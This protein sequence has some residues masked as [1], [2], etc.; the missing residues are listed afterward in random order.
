MLRWLRL[1]FVLAGGLSMVSATAS[2]QS[3]TVIFAEN[4]FPVAD[5]V[6]VSPTALQQ[7]F[8]G[9]RFANAAQL[10]AALTHAQLLVLPYGSA[11]PEAVWP[12]ILRYLERGGNLIVLGGKPF[13]RAAYKTDKGWRLRPESVTASLELFIAD[14]QPTPGSS[15]LRFE[16]NSDVQPTLPAF[17]W[18]RAFSP[19]IRL[20]TAP[21][22]PKD[23]GSIGTE[24][25]ELTTLAWGSAKEHRLDAPVVLIDRLQHRFVGGRWIFAACEP[26]PGA[27]DNSQLLHQLQ[28]LALRHGD[29]FSFSP[30]LPLFLSGEPLDFHFELA[31]SAQPEPGDVLAVAWRNEQGAEGKLTV[32]AEKAA[33]VV[34]PAEAAKGN[35]LHG[36]EATLLRAGAPLWT[37]RT[38][39]W[40]RDLEYL[41]SGP[42]LTVGKDYF[43]LDGRPLPVVGT[44]Y[45]SSDA[46]RLYL[47]KPNPW[48]WDQDMAQIRGNGLNMLR[49]GIWSGWSLLTQ[50]DGAAKEETL[51]AIEAFLMTA[52]RHQ[53]PVQFNLFA[54]LPESLGGGNAYLDPAAWARQD[55]YVQSITAR[56][57]D[58]PFLAWDLINE[59]S[60]NRNYWKTLPQGD[61]FEQSAWK[62][63]LTQHYPDQAALLAAWNEPALGV[64]RALQ[65]KPTG[66]PL[67]ASAQDPLAL[68][69][70]GA[71]EANAAGGGFNP[72]KDYDYMLFT[73]QIFVDWVVRQ[74]QTIRATGS[75]QLITVGQDEGGVAWRLSPA[76]FSPQ[77]D[78]TANHTWWDYDAIL[79]ASLSAKMPG[80]PMLIQEMGE[81]RRVTPDARLRLSAEEEGWQLERKLALSFAQGAGGIEWV[82]NVNARMANDNEIPIGAVRPDGSQKPE[83]A[84]LAGFARFAA[85]HPEKFTTIEPP[86]VTL[87]SSQSAFFSGVGGLAFE[88]QKKALR[89][90]A[91]RNHTPARILPENRFDAIGSPRL[92]ILPA[93]Q[94]LS[95]PAWQKLLDYVDRGGCLLITGPLEHDEHWGLAGRLDSLKEHA[96]L[97]PLALRESSLRLPGG[98]QP[99]ELSF[100]A[101]VQQ[102]PA[103]RLRFVDGAGDD[104]TVRKIAHGKGK[105]L[106][107]ADPVE[108]TED[109]SP[110]TALYAWA[111]AEA[112]VAP[113]YQ[114]LQPL[115]PGVLAFP[116]LLPDAV[117][118]SFSSES[119]DSSEVD[120]VDAFTH[121]RLHFLLP[122]ERGAVLL[123]DRA[124]GKVL[125][126]YGVEAAKGEALPPR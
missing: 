93:A 114:Q 1:C 64:G 97:L 22:L 34:L 109:Y 72:L 117:L 6:A 39:F 92:A 68:P 77:V 84:V 10:D 67:A 83:V 53:L 88:A 81:Q 65:A 16:A 115:S 116:T 49:S 18:K 21:M 107:V 102:S 90:L 25:A 29:R 62:S 74:R 48:V 20:A 42:K 12:A 119:M 69:E 52:R 99:I 66:A 60:A 51:R 118:Y 32:P 112:G 104:V 56:F 7:G 44:T 19:V 2:A 4:G 9:A 126:S 3:A 78:F 111:L 28:T 75:E 120:L 37:Y 45:M 55:R 40:M 61:A 85:S 70:A 82:W 59:P 14:Y 8:A 31:G 15:G 54:F 50:P 79:W 108:L 86:Q 101:T 113:A 5:S 91:Y 23:L 57:H 87:L 41:R 36:V 122:A 106:W 73:Q 125:S 124:T 33:S 24:D 71:F 121:A 17:A 43:Q 35:G 11:Y 103:E 13:L 89:T 46:D 95:E 105:I 96:Q 30:R 38:G 63:W 47:L 58:L 26:E 94:A 123:L 110:A 98:G 80:K 76:F 27:L 100:P